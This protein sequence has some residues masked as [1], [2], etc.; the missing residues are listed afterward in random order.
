MVS[1]FIL[2]GKVI[3]AEEDK[4]L[5]NWSQST[6][7]VLGVERDLWNN[8][9]AVEAEG[10]GPGVR[11]QPGLYGETQSHPELATFF[12]TMTELLMETM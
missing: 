10:G 11:G 7:V 5:L 6:G 2:G 12:G 1:P 8:T 3:V 4:E 9:R